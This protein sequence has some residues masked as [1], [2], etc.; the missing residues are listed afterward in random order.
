MSGERLNEDLP[1]LSDDILSGIGSGGPGF[2][3]HRW[4][5][6]VFLIS[7]V[8]NLKQRSAGERKT[9]LSDYDS[10]TEWIAQFQQQGH[11]QFRHMLR[12]FCFPD[13]VE[14]MSSNR[15]RSAVLA[16]FGI[17]PEKEAKNWSDRQLDDALF[18]LRDSLQKAQPSEILDFYEEPLRRR[19]RLPEKETE[20]YIDDTPAINSS[21]SFSAEDSAVFPAIQIAL[22]GKMYRKQTKRSLNA[23][24]LS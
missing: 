13:R 6:I 21:I 20:G 16:G 3:N 2:N 15:E 9:L 4:R 18:K 11:R 1:P 19:W 14:R 12:F 10:F 17:V 5:E 23:Y 22:I 8:G 24:G 7:L